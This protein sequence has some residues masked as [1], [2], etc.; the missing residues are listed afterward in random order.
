[1]KARRQAWYRV[2]SRIRS[3]LGLVQ[4]GHLEWGTHML[5]K[6]MWGSGR[7]HGEPPDMFFPEGPATVGCK[8]SPALEMRTPNCVLHDIVV[9]FF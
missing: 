2:A 3:T 6:L 1:M 5:S 7:V 9:F 4:K 8:A